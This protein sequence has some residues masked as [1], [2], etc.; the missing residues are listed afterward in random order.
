M[1]MS[2]TITDSTLPCTSSVSRNGMV[3]GMVSAQECWGIHKGGAPGET[4]GPE[5]TRV[6]DTHLTHLAETQSYN[7]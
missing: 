3:T 1:A 5:A 7:L 2:E 6:A 4:E